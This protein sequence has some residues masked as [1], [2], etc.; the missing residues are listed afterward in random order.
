MSTA[1]MLT[2][3]RRLL[4]RLLEEIPEEQLLVVP[5]GHRNNI[6]WNVGHLIV[7]QQLLHYRLSDLPLHVPNEIV[8]AFRTGTSPA[9]WTETPSR[10]RLMTLLEPLAERLAEDYARGAFVEYRTYR[11]STGVDLR[12]IEDALAFNHFHEGLH[13]GVIIAQR[14]LLS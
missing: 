13:V 14:K 2:Q 5:P 7:V 12:S 1:A 8:A 6:L 4:K 9:D 3:E 10:E 11:T